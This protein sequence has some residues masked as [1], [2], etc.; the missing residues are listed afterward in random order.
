MVAEVVAITPGGGRIEALP[1]IHVRPFAERLRFLPDGSRLV[2]LA[3]VDPTLEFLLLDLAIGTHRQITELAEHILHTFDVTP[4]GKDI[5]F[6]RER[7]NLDVVLSDR[8]LGEYG[9][10]AGPS[11]RPRR[12]V[13]DRTSAPGRWS[14]G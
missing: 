13:P 1:T 2:Y 7:L 8:R 11:T 9:R 5:V 4:D 6:D 10:T 3:G 12:G 14:C